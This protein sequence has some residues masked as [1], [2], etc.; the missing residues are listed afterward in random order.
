MRNTLNPDPEIDRAWTNFC[1]AP[2]N[3]TT[4]FTRKQLKEFLLASNGRIFAW[5]NIWD[6]KSKHLGAGVYRVSVERARRRYPLPSGVTSGA[7]VNAA[8]RPPS[9]VL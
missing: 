5:G 9:S 3:F 1:S 4:T 6:V 8:I 7:S 2:G